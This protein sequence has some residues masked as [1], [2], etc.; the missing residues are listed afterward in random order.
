MARIPNTPSPT[1]FAQTWSSE[2]KTAAAR[3]AGK[4]GRLSVNEA[5]KLAQDVGGAMFADNVASYFAQTGKKTVSVEVLAHD[6][7]AYAQRAAEQAAGPD[8]KLSLEDGKKLPQDLVEDFFLLRGKPVP[9]AVTPP[10]GPSTLPAVKAAL[11]AATANLLMP[12]ETD[13]SFAFLSGAQ[14]GGAAITPDV[15][16][17]QL[18]AQHD[19]ALPGLMYVSPG[20]GSLAAK[21]KVEVLPGTSYLQRIVDNADPNDPD[22]Q[23]MA[24]RFEGLIAAVNANLTDVQVMRFGDVSIST[25]IVG[26]TQSGELAALLT[27]QVET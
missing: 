22:S 25:F 14:L 2:L 18:T 24:A 16:R 9:G 1:S 17:A 15:V 13:A 20:E 5:K 4:D 19:A 23:A 26:R 7:Q 21:T 3:V 10:A 27:G 8:K 12:S 6:M 11:E